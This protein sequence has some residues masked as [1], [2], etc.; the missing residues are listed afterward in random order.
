ML[1]TLTSTRHTN[2]VSDAGA[3][4]RG[5]TARGGLTER[6]PRLRAVVDGVGGD[7][8]AALLLGV[9]VPAHGDRSVRGFDDDDGDVPRICGSRTVGLARRE[10]IPG[11]CDGGVTSDSGADVED[12]GT[13]TRL[14]VEEGSHRDIIRLLVQEACSDKTHNWRLLRR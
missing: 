3:V 8:P 10:G 2:A 1:S 4:R 9:R 14:V 5:R 13:V 11:A 12:S 7:R 6:R